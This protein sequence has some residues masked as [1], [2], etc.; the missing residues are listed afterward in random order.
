ML[1]V[2]AC[3]KGLFSQSSTKMTRKTSKSLTSSIDTIVFPPCCLM[4]KNYYCNKILSG[5]LAPFF[6]N[7]NQF[8]LLLLADFA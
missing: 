3:H 1:H 6:L 2:I 4:I 5:S 7:V 8:F